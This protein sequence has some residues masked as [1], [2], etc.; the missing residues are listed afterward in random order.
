MLFCPLQKRIVY[1]VT[2]LRLLVL[3]L[4]PSS[5]LSD[6]GGAASTAYLIPEIHASRVGGCKMSISYF[7]GSSLV[8]FLLLDDGDDITMRDLVPPPGF[9]RASKLRTRTVLG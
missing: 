9:S 5:S 6:P 2:L 8:E 1:V 4:T 3:I 7:S